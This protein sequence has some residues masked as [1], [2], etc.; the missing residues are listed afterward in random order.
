MKQKHLVVLVAVLVGTLVVALIATSARQGSVDV[1]DSSVLDTNRVL[2]DFPVN[3]V[4][5]FSIEDGGESLHLERKD[6]IWTVRERKSYP[7]DFSQVKDFLQKIYQLEPVDHVPVGNLYDRVGVADPEAEET[8]NKPMVLSFAKEGEESAGKLWVGKEYQKAQASQ[9]GSFDS[10]VGRYVRQP[11][12]EDVY[13]VGDALD[14]AKTDPSEWLDGEF[15][16]VRKI[17]SIE[18]LPEE[19]EQGWKLTREEDKGDF[20]LANPKEGEELDQNKVSSM[21]SA[22][23]SPRFEDVMTGDDVEAPSLVTFKVETFDG[24]SYVLNFG[25][26]SEANE[27]LMSVK[28]DGKFPKKRKA[29]EGESDEDKATKDA[30]FEAELKELQD[31]LAAEKKLEGHI[32]KVR[33]FVVDSVDKPRAELMKSEDDPAAPG[34]G[35][36]GGASG[37]P[38]LNLPPGFELPTGQ[39][40]PMGAPPA[41]PGGASAPETEPEAAPETEPEAAPEAKTEPASDPESAKEEA[42]PKAEADQ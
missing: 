4:S 37:I 7:A 41:A 42:A 21:K 12:S 24:F 3:E 19:A 5:A 29:E 39:L 14:D 33:S 35:A 34:A 23:S 8:E 11:G 26:K 1:K 18:R 25:E 28:V 32:Y 16:K 13:L 22:F 2:P 36:P 9:F 31:K 17:K 10:T 6:G 38:G 20:V 30:A 15:I 40:G 27:Y